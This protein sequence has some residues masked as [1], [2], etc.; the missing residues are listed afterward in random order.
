[1]A[2]LAMLT[3]YMAEM[4]YPMHTGPALIGGWKHAG[5]FEP[6]LAFT[7]MLLVILTLILLVIIK[8]VIMKFKLPL[9]NPRRSR[10]T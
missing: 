1:M 5:G 7:A 8:I 6:Q 3:P 9:R 4:A 10:V 2:A